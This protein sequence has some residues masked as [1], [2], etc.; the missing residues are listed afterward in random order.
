[1]RLRHPCAISS[2]VWKSSHIQSHS[3]CL[4]LDTDFCN[5]INYAIEQEEGRLAKLGA[6]PFELPPATY[7]AKLPAELVEEE[8]EEQALAAAEASGMLSPAAV[9]AVRAVRMMPAVQL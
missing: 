3:H 5:Y 4:R 7:G 6:T 8:R 1:M 2:P 9:S